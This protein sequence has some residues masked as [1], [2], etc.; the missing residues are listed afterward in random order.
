MWNYSHMVQRII[1]YGFMLMLCFSGL[2]AQGQKKAK[3]Q[4]IKADQLIYDKEFGQDV[5]RLMGDVVFKHKTTLMYCDS[6]YLLGANN[7]LI[8]Y[9]NVHINDNDS[10]HIYS[11]SLYYD[12]EQR[13]AQ[14]YQN[15]R[16]DDG[17]AQL[18]TNH[19]NYSLKTKQGQY[20]N[21]GEIVNADNDLKSDQGYYYVRSHRAFFKKDVFL[22]NPDYDILCD[23]LI[24]NTE[25]EIAY[26]QGPTNIVSDENLIYCENGWYNTKNDKSQF[27]KNAYLQNEKQRI[28][29]DS[30]YYSRMDDFG[31]AFNNVSVVD[32]SQKV[33]VFGQYLYYA[34]MDGKALVTDSALAIMED[35]KRDS[36]YLHS[37]SLIIY[38]DSAQEA[39]EILSFHHVSI[40]K[41]NFQALCDSLYYSIQD[42]IAELYHEPVLWAEKSQLTGNFIK[43]YTHNNNPK[44]MHVLGNAFIISKDSLEYFNQISG[45]DMK[46]YFRDGNFRKLNVLG[47]SETLYFARDEKKALIGVDIAL[48]SDLSIYFKNEEIDNIVYFQ[49]PEGVIHPLEELSAKELKL[50]NY[51]NLNDIKPLNPQ[52]VFLWKKK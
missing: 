25:S 28:Q 6:A 50:K 4:L 14:F 7:S 51:R 46:A 33:S 22:K 40:Y 13:L 47:N 42:S 30:L 5:Q 32:T 21:G 2:L 45:K 37:D 36:I 9:G 8:A 11:D 26:F 18:T 44:E 15:I 49:D 35:D 24:Y 23:T 3:I 52:E 29:G 16:M 34:G 41:S 31:E 1:T 19:L 38:F 20:F 17:R 43:L 10:V 12:G 39:K 48:A 27:N